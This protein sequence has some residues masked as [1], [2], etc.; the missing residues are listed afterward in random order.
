MANSSAEPD[1]ALHFF[2]EQYAVDESAVSRILD[3][4][5]EREIDYADLY[6][7]YATQDSVA[8]RGGHRQERQSTPLPGR[9]GPGPVGERQG[10]AHSDEISIDSMRLAA[11]TARAISREPCSSTTR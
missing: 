10:Y 1:S 5:L 6:F 2:R 11:S 3:T 7:E 9:R 8:T 4:A